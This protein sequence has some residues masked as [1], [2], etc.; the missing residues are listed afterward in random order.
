MLAAA[1]VLK[2]G[3]NNLRVRGGV[4]FPLEC[5]LKRRRLVE[6]PSKKRLVSRMLQL[7]PFAM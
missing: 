7:I 5:Y 4:R 2:V 6:E 3:P 1:H